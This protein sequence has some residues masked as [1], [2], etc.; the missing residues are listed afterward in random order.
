MASH[1][2]NKTMKKPEE[3]LSRG[4]G[5]FV[6]CTDYDDAIKAIKKYAQQ[7]AIEFA[8]WVADRVNEND[9]DAGSMFAFTLLDGNYYWE[10]D[11]DGNQPLSEEDL[12]K[13]F[14]EENKNNKI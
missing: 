12:Y 8:K 1:Y 3:M 2:K 10:D 14:L 6:N 5:R 4:E 9:K 7:E 13:M 11:K